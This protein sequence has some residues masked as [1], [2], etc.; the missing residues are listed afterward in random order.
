MQK[1]YESGKVFV[2]NAYVNEM[3]LLRACFVNF[4]SSE[5]ELDLLLSMVNQ[6]GK[7]MQH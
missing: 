6:L 3:F 5:K 4:R 1:L 2:S 7:E